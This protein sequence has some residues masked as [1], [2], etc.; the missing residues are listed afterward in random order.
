MNAH[1]MTLIEKQWKKHEK[2]MFDT[3]YSLRGGID[4]C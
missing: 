1:G 3:T 4:G 2:T